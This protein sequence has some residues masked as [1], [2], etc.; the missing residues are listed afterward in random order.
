MRRC[1]KTYRRPASIISLVVFPFSFSSRLI[2]VAA[3]ARP[4]ATA[5]MGSATRDI[6]KAGADIFQLF[7][8]I[9]R[10]MT[11]INNFT[12]FF[13]KKVQDQATFQAGEALGWVD[14]ENWQRRQGGWAHMSWSR[15]MLSHTGR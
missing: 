3:A 7:Q 4:M 2:L 5:K 6:M 14:V 13:L 12:V 8:L 11:L 1:R 9:C 15:D 10:K